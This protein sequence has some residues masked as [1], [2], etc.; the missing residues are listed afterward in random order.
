MEVVAHCI[1]STYYKELREE[2][3]VSHKVCKSNDRMV[4]L[5]LLCVF[6]R[7]IWVQNHL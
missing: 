6:Q 4:K 5:Q 7:V 1:F 3:L 2:L